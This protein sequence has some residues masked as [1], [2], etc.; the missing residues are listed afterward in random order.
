MGNIYID[1]EAG[2]P[3]CFIA[4]NPQEAIL[5]K[6]DTTRP[7]VYTIENQEKYLGIA[8]QII[9][10]IDLPQYYVRTSEIDMLACQ[11]RETV[12]NLLRVLYEPA[13]MI[14]NYSVEL[15]DRPP[16]NAFKVGELTRI[17]DISFIIQPIEKDLEG[18]KSRQTRLL[19][20][21]TPTSP[22]D[23]IWGPDRKQKMN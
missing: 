9:H 15:N 13:N 7:E 20:M 23:P 5:A 8:L 12:E 16:I 14:S 11:L 21:V 22:R 3:D 17:A 2:R 4:F 19:I 1:P 6:L 18:E 10:Q